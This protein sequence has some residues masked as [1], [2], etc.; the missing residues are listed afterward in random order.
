MTLS[1]TLE[2]MT[3]SALADQ[4]YN[5]F[6]SYKDAEKKTKYLRKIDKL[7][8]AD[9]IEITSKDFLEN[10]QLYDKLHLTPEL[11]L[12]TAKM[13]IKNI[14]DERFPGKNKT[15][16]LSLDESENKIS[17]VEALGS[18]FHNKLVEL[19]GVIVSSSTIYNTVESIIVICEMGHKEKI[20]SFVIPK[21]C[22]HSSNGITCN[23][24]ITSDEKQ[25]MIRHRKYYLKSDYEFSNH[26][27]E[28]MADIPGELTELAQPGDR[29]KIVGIVKTEQTKDKT[30]RNYLY[31]VGIKK[32]DDVDL[33][34]Y[35]DDEEIFRKLP[36]ELDF[37]NRMVNSI[38]PS[39]LGLESIKE[40]L[41]LQRVGSPDILKKDGTKTRGW[42]HVGLFGDPGTAKTKLGEWEKEN[43]P[44]TQLIMS[45]GATQ[46]GLIMGLEQGPD[47]RRILKVG[48]LVLCRDDGLTII[49]EFPRLDPEV[50]GGLYTTVENGIA[51]ISK[52]G[53]N[54]NTKANS[55]I[56]ATG[57]A[58]SGK[59]EDYLNIP[60][61][62]GIEATFLQRFD[63]MFII[64]DNFDTQTDSNL[65]DAMLNDIQ[66]NDY[67][68][69]H[70][71]TFLAKYLRFTR[72]FNPELTPEVNSHLKKT[73]L[74]LRKDTK[75]KENGVSPRHLNTL[76]R[77]TLA[78]AR[79]Y[80]RPYAIL[81]DA[82]KAINLV[83]TM[84]EQQNIS[85]AQADTYLTRNFNKAISVLEAETL[86][87]LTSLELFD[88]CQSY[89]TNQD[90]EEFRLDLGTIR[91]V[92]RNKKW[93]EVIALLKRSP[94]IN[95]LTEKPLRMAIKKDK[96]RISSY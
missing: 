56:L 62:L 70:S 32:L 65:A 61:N 27:D 33:R 37:Y 47:N 83:K 88:K 52:S 81:E 58:I 79:I 35:S 55:P 48:A 21:K 77:T 3:E 10:S 82:T 84:F 17:I 40:A 74:E 20:D 92:E 63:F 64:K 91:E 87:G 18:K 4:L 28:I 25:E 75:A 1:N 73:W 2:S 29:V 89:G 54:V 9:F 22:N 38:A 24:K 46:P 19:T 67:A 71:P 34:I 45:K 93:R 57:N 53:F 49:D 8:G 72:Q 69:P 60:D 94:R 80:Q 14:F 43:L 78:I 59:W 7:L 15:F 12:K 51:S 26:Y 5:F 95:I 68:R 85:I 44:K 50:I 39:V 86:D 13:A 76:I 90:N 66:Y 11:F 23:Q 16:D 42:I 96:G 31:A 30:F 6:N 41:L 36:E